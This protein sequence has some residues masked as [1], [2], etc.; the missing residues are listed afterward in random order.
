KMSDRMDRRLIILTVS[1]LSAGML[2]LIALAAHG[3]GETISGGRGIVAQSVAFAGLFLLGATL[4]P[5]YS[6]LIAHACDRAAPDYI[7]SSAVS[8]LFIYTLGGVIGPLL[9]AAMNN[10]LGPNATAWAISVLMFLFA[11][12]T[13][14]R[15][16]LKAPVK[17]SEQASHIPVSNTSVQ[18]QPREK[19]PIINTMTS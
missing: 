16:Q 6:L 14:M 13:V 5:L 12:L 4:M 8:L 7:A 18:M 3:D 1:L 10:A 9:A 17:L 19:K 2:A 15:M 11:G